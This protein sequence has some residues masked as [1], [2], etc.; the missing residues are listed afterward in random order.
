[1]YLGIVIVADP[2][3]YISDRS[4]TSQL[5]KIRERIGNLVSSKELQSEIRGFK[6]QKG[7]YKPRDSNY[8]IWIRQ[9]VRGVY[10][11][12]EPDYLPDG[13]WY[14]RYTPEAKNG[15][16]DLSLST[17]RALFRAIDDRI[18]VGVFIQREIHGSE[19]IYEVLG[20]AYVE[21][22]DGSHFIMHG[23]PIDVDSI[24]AMRNEIPPFIPYDIPTS[25]LTVSM[26]KQRLRAFQIG[27]R[28][29]YHEK[30][31]LCELGYHFNGQPIGIEAAHLIPFSDN[32][33]SRDLRNG[34]LLCSN[35]HA[36]FD[37]NLWTF[38]ED[39][40]VVVKD[41]RL[42]RKSAMNN[43]VLKAEG[44]RLPNLPDNEFDLPAAEAIKYRLSQ[45]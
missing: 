17:N 41:D 10:P 31:S 42:F 36:L 13:S 33:T 18:P 24:P 19:R 37:K 4:I 15:E 1:M 39:Y 43:H 29:V 12:K 6:T 5:Y 27:I 22:F 9:T 26:I 25:T 34:I 14:Y 2:V 30:C 44:K 23:E 35:H 45:I 40:R 7:I 32:G 3:S 20:L 21:G 28:H 8:A 16:T 38:D 11:D